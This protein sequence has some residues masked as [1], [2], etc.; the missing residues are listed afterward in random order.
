[1]V[2]SEVRIINGRPRLFIDNKPQIPCAYMTYFEER[3]C[4]KDFA[5]IGYNLYSLCASFSGLPLNN[6][7]GF[8]PHYGIFDV[9]GKPDYGRFD[10]YVKDIVQSCPDAK[11]FLRVWVSMPLW[12][13]EEHPDEV[14]QS[15][16]VLKRE[17]LFSKSLRET[18]TDLLKQFISHIQESDYCD[19]IIGYQIA[20]GSTEEWFHADA[21]GSQSVCAKER[22][23][24][25]LKH[26]YPDKYAQEVDI[27]DPSTYKVEGVIQNDLAQ[28]YLEFV[29]YAT[30]DTVL[31]LAK[32]AKKCVNHSQIV[33]AFYGY[34]PEIA[35]PLRGTMGLKK[36]LESPDIDFICSPNSYFKN[37]A[38]GIDWAEHSLGE[39]IKQRGKLYFLENDIRTFLSDYP[40]KCRPGCD[41]HNRYNTKVWLGPPTI[42]GSIWGMRKA[43]ARHYTHG[44]GLWWFDMWGGW[45]A[46]SELLEEARHCRKLL[47][48]LHLTDME[49]TR[50][51]VAVLYDEKFPFRVGLKDKNA[52]VQEYIHNI[53]GNTGMT[54]DAL[55]S[56][57]YEQ[58]VNYEAVLI[59]FP[60]MFDTEETIKIKQ[61]LTEKG[62]P[63]AQLSE[64]HYNITPAQLREI[65]VN[66]GVHCY[67]DTD[68]VIYHGNGILCIHSATA[69][70]KTINLPKICDITPLKSNIAP[71]TSNKIEL[72]MNEF[73]TQLF[74]IN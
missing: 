45:Y 62:I 43:F 42:E 70:H 20:G 8:A 7:T 16:G 26:Y 51:Q 74:K 6:G 1:M 69:G 41:P 66:I 37:R 36:L 9:K 60:E 52:G 32:V 30:A 53:F 73:E 54:S 3:A 22:F 50:S 58:S 67:C 56:E 10:G 46:N 38:L 65:L 11:I 34:V 68:D 55:L 31:H 63:F 48:E 2:T 23:N 64:E 21:N 61:Y 49:L 44:N 39:S 27:P 35:N 25:Y 40:N 24:A 4:Y 14:C 13:I 19:H 33:G 71:F 17:A 15:A 72:E 29:N 12:W 57:D 47:S 59:P 5:D 28:R 18:G